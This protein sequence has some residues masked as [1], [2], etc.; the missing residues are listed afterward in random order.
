MNI[1]FKRVTKNLPEYK[2]IKQLYF[3]A[4]PA[5][6]RAPFFLMT[7]RTKRKDVDFLAIYNDKKWVGFIYIINHL[8]LSYVFYF[9]LNDNERGKGIGSAVLEKIKELYNG[10]R[11]F[12]ALETLDKTADNYAQRISRSNFYQK[13]GLNKLNIAIKEGNVV[14]DAMGFGGEVKPKEYTEMMLNYTG[15][16]FSKLYKIEMYEK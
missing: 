15:F 5:E 12:L 8:D 4:F 3:S 14:Y 7:K 1:E 13:N 11:F 10:R 2:R 6:E 9:A 16:F